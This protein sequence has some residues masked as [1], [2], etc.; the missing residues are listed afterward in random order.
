M[1]SS[2]VTRNK[3]SVDISKFSTGIYL[4]KINSGKQFITKKLIIN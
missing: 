2:E 1:Q 3:N 4:L